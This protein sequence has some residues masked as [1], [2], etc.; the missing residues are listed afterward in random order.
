VAV[1]PLRW[2]SSSGTSETAPKLPAENV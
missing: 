1:F 2:R